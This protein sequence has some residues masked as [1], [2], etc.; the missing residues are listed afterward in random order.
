MKLIP[1]PNL[2][3]TNENVVHLHRGK[4]TPHREGIVARCEVDG[5]G[6][7]YANAQ[8]GGGYAD[9]VTFWPRA[10][11]HIWIAKGAVYL[12]RV[13]QAYSWKHYD[14]FGISC[15]I[16][17]DQK[18][19]ILATHTDVICLDSAGFVAWQRPVAVDGV[20]IVAIDDE[21]IQCRVCHDPPN[22]WHACKLDR[23][24]GEDA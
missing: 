15:R 3:A 17:D 21:T 9:V 8:P 22:G 1:L 2:P 14:D 4:P 5:N 12:V 10:N 20:Q 24:T 13:D 16:A 23:R 18:N 6:C 7:W 11:A 19:A